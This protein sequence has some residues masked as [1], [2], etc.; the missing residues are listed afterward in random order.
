MSAARN[1][2]K[3]TRPCRPRRCETQRLFVPSIPAH[4]GIEP[5]HS[6][7]SGGSAVHEV[8]SVGVRAAM[9]RFEQATAP[10]GGSAVHEVTSVGVA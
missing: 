4:A 8:T 10:S 1:R 9:N 5:R 2:F 3:Q 6:A 7:P